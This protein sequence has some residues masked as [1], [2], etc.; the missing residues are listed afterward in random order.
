MTTSY[1]CVEIDRKN[2]MCESISLTNS[3]LCLQLH[4]LEGFPQK[5]SAGN[6]RFII[7][8]RI[9]VLGMHACVIFNHL[10][11]LLSF[12]TLYALLIELREFVDEVE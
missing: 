8:I 5:N 1:L 12:H 11:L 4:S 2:I 6:A 3:L 10:S 9:S 7:E